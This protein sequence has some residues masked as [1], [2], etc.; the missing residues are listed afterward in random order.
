MS[1]T[2]E[3]RYRTLQASLLA[4]ATALADHTTAQTLDAIVVT[5]SRTEQRSFDTP[6]AIDAIGRDAIEAAGPQVNLSESLN[7]VPGLAILNRQNYAQ[8]LQISIRG[9]GARSTFGVRGIRLLIDDIP[10]TTPDG[11]GQA[12]SVSLTST[13]RIEVLRGPLAQLYGNSAGGVIRTFTRDPAPRPIAELRGFAGSHGLVRQDWQVSSPLVADQGSAGIVADF[14]ALRSDG[15]RANSHAERRQF[16]GKLVVAPSAATRVQIVANRFDSPIAEDPLGLTAAQLAEDP[17]QAGSNAAGTVS[18]TALRTRKRVGQGQV[19]VVARHEFAAGRSLLLRG[20]VG[21][22]DNLQFQAN[23]AWVALDRDYAGAGIQY[24]QPAKPFGLPTT[25]VAG[26]ELDRSRERR[27]GGSARA[28]EKLATTRDELNSAASDDWYLQSTTLLSERYSLIAGV[29]GSRIRL[30]SEDGYLADG[31]DGSGAVRYRAINPVIGL[32]WHAAPTLNLY[33]SWGRGFETPTLAEVAYRSDAGGGIV[34]QFNP[35][36]SAAKSRHAEL[37]VKWTPTAALRIDAAAFRIRS[38]DEI[39]TL[40][41]AG[42]TVFQN[43][44]GTRRSGWE[45]AAATLWSPQLSG[46]LAATRTVAEFSS[47]YRAI[48]GGTVE[49]IAAGNRL[50]GVPAA[51]LFA[52]LLWSGRP[53][54]TPNAATFGPRAGIELVGAGRL[55]ADDRNTASNAGYAVWNA[56]ASYRADLGFGRLTGYLRVDNVGD[57]RYVGSVIVNQANAQYHEPAPG[58]QWLVGASL[59]V[60]I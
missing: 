16:N 40:T 31:A 2:H 59:E 22:R 1:E 21:E 38:T 9:Y 7:R 32:T 24:T 6:A 42:N 58:R 53:R 27:T 54:A 12:S 39:V 33:G 18:A 37:G 4:A 3:A 15:Y 10:A 13:E 30:D 44:P 51:L 28:G 57:R 49:T 46:Q 50:P 11:Q 60:P 47:G 55:W 17:R 36:L 34:P 29:R 20:H 5:G 8:D 56:K 25:V 43:A 41:S 48:R 19:G 45:L 23:N 35:S 26:I 14:S 52:E